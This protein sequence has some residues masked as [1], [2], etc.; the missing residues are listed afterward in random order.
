MCSPEFTLCVCVGGGG[1]EQE[2]GLLPFCVC[3]S[4]SRK[5]PDAGYFQGFC[6]LTKR[7]FFLET[8]HF[9]SVLL[10]LPQSG[11]R[12]CFVGITR[13]ECPVNIC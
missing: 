11:F 1:R 13:L 2:A 12:G 7:Y 8:D 4:C 5:I 9:Y 3:G 10:G 6:F